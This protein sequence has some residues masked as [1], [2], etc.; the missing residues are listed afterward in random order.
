M[1]SSLWLTARAAK[2][3]LLPA[4]RLPILSVIGSR[5]VIAAAGGIR[6]IRARRH[7]DRLKTAHRAAVHRTNAVPHHGELFTNQSIELRFQAKFICD[8]AMM[9]ARHICRSLH[10]RAEIEHVNEYLPMA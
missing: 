6:W 3:P 7:Q 2:R 1:R 10:I 8:L 9:E 5:T 4:D